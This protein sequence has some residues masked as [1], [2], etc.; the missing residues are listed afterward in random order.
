[1]A[2]SRVTS[3]HSRRSCRSTRPWTKRSGGRSGR[4]PP[5]V[6]VLVVSGDGVRDNR[7]GWHLLPGVLDRLGYTSKGAVPA[8]GPPPSPS[9]MGR[10]A[11]LVPAGVKKRI[12]DNLPLKVRNRLSL[13]SQA[14]DSTGLR[15]RA[16]A[17]PTDLEGCIRINLKGREPQGIVERGG[18]YEDLCRE[19]RAR[20]EELVS[21]ALGRRHGVSGSATR[22]SRDPGRRSYG[23]HG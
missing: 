10:V 17:L 16:L 21:R 2:S 9:L 22:S 3:V 7:C 19:I 20:L 11:Q 15:T 12:S 14:A 18:Q 1:M 5:Q 4:L 6:A 23:S 13:L 8:N